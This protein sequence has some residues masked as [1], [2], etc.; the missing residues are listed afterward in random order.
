M[1]GRERRCD[2]RTM[3]FEPG[4]QDERLAQG[5]RILVDRKAGA[6]GRELEQHPTGFLEVN[7]LEPE[8]IDYLSRT[9]PCG[10]DQPPHSLLMGG[11]IHPPGQMMNAADTPGPTA[12]LRR[13]L[14][15][16]VSA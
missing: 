9:P 8:S 6:V 2:L 1:Q 13:R 15:V 10:L 11:V 7:R 16:D 5:R 4:R 3:A 14:H 12:G